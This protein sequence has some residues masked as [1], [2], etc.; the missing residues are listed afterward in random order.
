MSSV[1]F[2]GLNFWPA[3]GGVSA[4]E[5]ARFP[6]LVQMRAEGVGDVLWELRAGGG[7][8][9]VCGSENS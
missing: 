5:V 9:G 7:V 4:S 8:D 1:M 6:G 2:C 3:Y